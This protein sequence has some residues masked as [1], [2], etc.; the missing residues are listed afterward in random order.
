[1]NVFLVEH[2]N[3]ILPM[4]MAAD[5]PKIDPNGLVFCFASRFASASSFVMR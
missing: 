4:S 1:M 5:N 3:S 2:L